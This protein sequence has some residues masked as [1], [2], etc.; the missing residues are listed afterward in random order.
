MTQPPISL[1]GFDF[2]RL[3]GSGGYADVYL[4]VQQLPRRRVAVKVLR[5]ASTDAAAR[6]RFESEANLMA[7]LSSHPSI[8]TIHHA[9]VA[10]DGRPYLVMEHCSRPNLAEQCRQRVLSVPEMLQTFVRLSG[11]IETAHRAGILHRDIK[12]ANVL[13]TDYGWPALSDFGISSLTGSESHSG[14]LSLPWAPPEAVLGHPL[15]SRSDVYSLAATAYTVLTGHA[16]F[17]ETTTDTA[18]A[19]TRIIRDPVPPTGR[20]DVPASLERLLS[21]ALA[22][23]PLSRPQSAS[24]F[25]RSL[26]RIEQE[27]HLPVTHLDILQSDVIA[28]LAADDAEST[29]FTG[30]RGAGVA[31][32][33]ASSRAD[34]EDIV[35]AT[36]MSSRPVV[37]DSTVFSP[38]RADDA[39]VMSPRPSVDDATVFSPRQVD[40]ATVFSPRQS[41]DHTR[42]VDRTPPPTGGDQEDEHDDA[43]RLTAPAV[44]DG[45]LL[46]SSH[47]STPAPRH[48][49]VP[50]I[51]G[52]RVA[53]SADDAGAGRVYGVRDAQP[54][55][56]IVRWNA[57]APQAAT[58]A[59]AT[60]RRGTRRTGLVVAIVVGTAL[61]GTAVGGIAWLVS[62]M[63][64]TL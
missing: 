14:A 54:A 11:A 21:M 24:E 12:P 28:P 59:P 20:S 8:V 58:P 63:T 6:A 41:D 27:M 7:A 47:R 5:E 15:D 34:S 10:D 46:A 40:D 4:C 56:Q 29:V 26:Q 25:A 3:L 32:G 50:V 1:P 30:S 37:D 9:S 13:S 62:G 16:P 42:L 43:T 39:T 18:T 38:R 2:E 31:P 64:E 49:A 35:D 44:E 48:D 57:P 60:R 36:V 55:E 33:A 53:S 61:L 17:P 45:T 23:D 51:P 22:K 52:G 19:V